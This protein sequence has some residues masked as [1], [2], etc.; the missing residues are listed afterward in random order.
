MTLSHRLRFLKGVIVALVLLGTAG[1][2]V[3]GEWFY[4][5]VCVGFLL[6]FVITLWIEE[7][8]EAKECPIR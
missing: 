8:E 7:R 3:G 2:V 5:G 1:T 4:A 6:G